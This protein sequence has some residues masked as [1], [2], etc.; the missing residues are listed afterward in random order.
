MKKIVFAK[1]MGGFGDFLCCLKTLYAI[2]Q[3][4]PHYTLIVYNDKELEFVRKIGFVDEVINS[5][6]VSLE[7]LCA[8]KPEIFI[9]T[10]RNS[11]FFRQLKTMK[12]QKLIAHPHFISV[13]SRAFT[14]PLPYFRGK[15]YLSDINLTLARAINSKH[16][17]ENIHKIDFSKIREFVPKETALSEAFFK[18]VDFAYKK[19][20]GINAFSNFKEANGFNFFTKDWVNLAF[21]LG[22]VYPQFLFVLLNF[23]KNLIQFNVQE[24]QNVRVFINNDNIASLVGMTLNL[25]YLI[26][27]DTGNVHL[28]N[29]LQVPNFVFI[30]KRMRYR[31]GGG[32]NTFVADFGWQKEYQK[33]LKAFTQEVKQKLKDLN[34]SSNI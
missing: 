10:L 25:D 3:L 23:Q 5:N 8:M 31:A 32:L 20:I 14:T 17:D 6:E 29:A 26:S 24:R 27:I 28:C 4:Y 18:K 15:K 1:D 22:R 19:V 9:T 13:T 2:K 33:T 11:A 34:T 21:E 16:Y 7:E 30:D 12:F